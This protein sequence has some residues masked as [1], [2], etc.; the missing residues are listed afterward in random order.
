MDGGGDGVFREGRV[1]ME[2]RNR[3][4]WVDGVIFRLARVG[5]RIE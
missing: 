1:E 4:G 3:T 2:R 5:R